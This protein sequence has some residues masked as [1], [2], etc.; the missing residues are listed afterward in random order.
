MSPSIVISLRCLHCTSEADPTILLT[1]SGYPLV[2]IHT[3]VYL[4]PTIYISFIFTFDILSGL[5]VD[6]SI[7]L[8][9]Q[10]WCVFSLVNNGM[11]YP[12]QLVQVGPMPSITCQLPPLRPRPVAAVV[13]EPS[14]W[15]VWS[16]RRH[17][18]P[19]PL[20]QSSPLLFVE[21]YVK[22][23]WNVLKCGDW[24]LPSVAITLES[25]QMMSSIDSFMD[26]TCFFHEIPDMPKLFKLNS[27]QFL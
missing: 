11:N 17:P 27:W 22:E 2:K 16:L 13:W 4:S 12:T 15:W 20:H 18:K 7:L 23:T 19:Y 25:K 26:R 9:T 14:S 1:R 24:L 8:L 6:G 21:S 10:L 5:T 3:L